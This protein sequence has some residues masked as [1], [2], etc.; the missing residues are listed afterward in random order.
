MVVL[1][2]VFSH[3]FTDIAF[4][5]L[6]TIVGFLAW[7]FFS[8]SCVQAMDGLLGGAAVMHKVYVPA[9]IFPLAA[10]AANFVNLL[11]SIVLLPVIVW[12]L[13]ATP[14][15]HLGW[16]VLALLL[17]FLFTVGLALALS[18][19]NLFFH[20]VR[21]FFDAGL[22]IWFYATPI[23][24]PAEVIPERY[25]AL[26]WLNPLH[27]IVAVLRA[28]LYE[29]RGPSG[30]ELVAASLVATASLVLGWLIFSR[31]ERRFHLYL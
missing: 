31:L 22:L 30:L 7:G 10:V 14:G 27:W 3:V 19:L 16:L 1:T 28:P 12:I 25:A 15:L 2:A 11:A 9:A 8:L 26:V 4:Y 6:Y 21:Y 13:G 23:V 18:A 29:G 17:L 20:D 24:Y 5:P